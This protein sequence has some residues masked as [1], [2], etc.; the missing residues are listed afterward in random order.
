MAGEKIEENYFFVEGY[1]KRFFD[2]KYIRQVF[3][4]LYIFYINES[5]TLKY[6]KPKAIWEVALSKDVIDFKY[7][8]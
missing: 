8:T 2:E 6:D 5:V 4:D 3:N 7:S 1:K